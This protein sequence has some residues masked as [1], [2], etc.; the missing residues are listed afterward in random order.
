MCAARRSGRIRVRVLA[1]RER[2]QR[3]ATREARSIFQES[4]RPATSL[5]LLVHYLP[6]TPVHTVIHSSR[7][8]PPAV[9][10][11]LEFA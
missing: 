5:Y 8:Q 9:P 1:G 3:E 11:G 6:L 4:L 7:F 10:V 2:R